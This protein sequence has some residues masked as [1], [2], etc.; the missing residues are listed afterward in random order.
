MKKTIAVDFDGVIHK[1]SKG[2]HNGSVY[3]DPVEGAKDAIND[4]VFEGYEVVIYSARP[5]QQEMREWLMKHDFP[6][7]EI[8]KE[9]PKAMAY[10]DDR[11]IRF[12]NWRDIKNYFI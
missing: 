9:K 10:V 4:L 1:Y 2:W 11:G 7:L 8:V 5:N 6:R 3:D 12:T